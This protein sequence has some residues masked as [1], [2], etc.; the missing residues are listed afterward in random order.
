MQKKEKQVSVLFMIFFTLFSICLIGSNLFAV[1]PF[2]VGKVSFMGAI[3]LFPMSYIVND[4][5]VE[6]WGFR[7]ARMMILWA[8]AF[9]FFIVV[10]GGLVD[11]LPGASWW[12]GTSESAGFHA[13][14]G[15]APRVAIASF[16]AFLVGSFVNAAVMSRIKVR[17]HGRHFIVR[18]VA[19]SLL[20]EFC[21]SMIFFPIALAGVVIP[22]S[23]MPRFVLWQVGLKTGYEVI[24]MPL[25]IQVVK[26]VK[27]C[28]GV[29][30]YDND[31]W[32]K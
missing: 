3:V 15:L 27:K 4:V 13:V 17:Q 23:E 10:I 32:Q 6:V 12:E 18:A 26:S 14:F 8:F 5:V 24:I 11:V 25:T 20:G 28:E 9:N 19:S 1:K 16:L 31:I 29:D 21:D 2:E 30:T 22:W 7:R